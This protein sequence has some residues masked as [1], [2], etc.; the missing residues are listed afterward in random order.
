M[1]VLREQGII[2]ENFYRKMCRICLQISDE[3]NQLFTMQF[4]SDSS[5][6]IIF[7][8]RICELKVGFNEMGLS[9]TSNN[10]ITFQIIHSENLPDKICSKCT[11]NVIIAFNLV[12]LCIGSDTALRNQET[13]QML[14]KIEAEALE[15]EI[16]LDDPSLDSIDQRDMEVSLTDVLKSEIFS[17]NV[18]ELEYCK[19][20]ST[21]KY[22]CEKCKVPFTNKTKYHKHLKSHDLT[23]QLKCDHCSQ[24][25]SKQLH[26]N[27]HLRSHMKNEDR[28]FVCS[29]CGKHFMFQYLLKQHSYK[30]T[31]EK[32]FPCKKCG[33]GKSK[34]FIICNLQNI[35]FINS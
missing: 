27:V 25:F 6:L 15:E 28:H 14:R 13:R 22:F 34:I 8:R 23:K 11:E 29:V 30:H 31:D 35:F 4:P 33:K 32:P 24:M 10:K 1:D 21:D 20:I 9:S 17:N 16:V 2:L 7:L 12:Q 18:K 5:E 26:L 3:M 19:G